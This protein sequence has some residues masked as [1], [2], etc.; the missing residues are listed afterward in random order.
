MPRQR[1]VRL[2]SSVAYFVVAYGILFFYANPDFCSSRGQSRPIVS[3]KLAFACTVWDVFAATCGALSIVTIGKHSRRLPI[4]V[5]TLVSGAG[6]VSIP[7]W[8]Y[9]GYGHFLFE[10]TRA[11][12]SCLFT[13]GFGEAFPFFVAPL[14]TLATLIRAWM[15]AKVADREHTVRL[16]GR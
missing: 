7:F 14:L 8:I 6:F 2:L 1:L 5:S 11:D 13:E 10:N 15:V 9:R 3:A 16:S 4:L 12:V